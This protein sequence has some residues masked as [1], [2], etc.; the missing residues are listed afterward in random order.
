M[1]E[2]R[3]VRKYT[4]TVEGETEQWYLLWL[5]DQINACSKRKADVSVVV[6]VQQ[7]PK[8]Y[9]KSVIT[10]ATPSI[11]HICD[12]ESNDPVHVEKLQR[13]LS[14]MKEAKDLKN[15]NYELGYSNFT[16]E[17][18]MVLHKKTF[19]S[20]LAHRT[21]YLEPIN[22]AFGERFEDLDHYKREDNFKRCLSKLT[23][24]DVKSAISRAEIIT[25]SNKTDGK[26]IIRY[27]G[28]SYY[29]DNPALSI[30]EAVHKMMIDCGL[31][32]MFSTGA[33]TIESG[34]E[35][36]KKSIS[37]STVELGYRRAREM[38][39]VKGPKALGIPGAGSYLYPIFLRLGV[40]LAE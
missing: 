2:R 6:K 1:S 15:I 32:D 7:S 11:T 4:F 34:G 25:D 22:Q 29:R 28:F 17:L 26:T 20:P 13:I 16:F 18:W 33:S 36:R 35:T 8:K 24:D 30:H 38:G 37:R 10:K 12:V 14:E 5:R 23:L 39:V 9:A 31:M 40:C 3:D 19:N 27:K 21:Q